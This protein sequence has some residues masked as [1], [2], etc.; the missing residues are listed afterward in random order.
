MLVPYKCAIQILVWPS[1]NRVFKQF[2]KAE[3]LFKSNTLL[4]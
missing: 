3:L 1:N 4:V 2:F